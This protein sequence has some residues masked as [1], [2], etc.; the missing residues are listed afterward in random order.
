MT[1]AEFFKKLQQSIPQIQRD[2][3]N[4]V[5]VVEAEH[6]W[7][8]NFNRE[9]F[10]DSGF[11]KW[12]PRKKK[13]A[14][15]ARKLLVKSSTLKAHALSGRVIGDTVTF[16]FPMVYARVHNEGLRAGRGAGFQ[17]PKRQFIGQS[18]KLEE[19]IKQKAIKYLDRKINN[20]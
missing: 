8:D 19:A 16:D 9:G 13:E 15:P 18:A 12:P 6:Q 3:L 20:L 5:I 7:A 14:G 1:P 17:M 2:I 4:T 10:T 11:T